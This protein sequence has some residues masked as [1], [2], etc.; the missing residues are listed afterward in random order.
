MTTIQNVC[1]FI[2]EEQISFKLCSFLLADGPYTDE[3]KSD[4]KGYVNDF[5]QIFNL[6][7]TFV[8]YR[9][10]HIIPEGGDEQILKEWLSIM[11]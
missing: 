6:D 2:N 9:G 8:S 7:Y 3:G 10:Y 11:A 1:G 4:L 5:I